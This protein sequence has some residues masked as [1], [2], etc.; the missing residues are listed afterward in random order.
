MA[1][2]NGHLLTVQARGHVLYLNRVC[3]TKSAAI[4][5][6]VSKTS[7]FV[8]HAACTNHEKMRSEPSR[9][10]DLTRVA[11]NIQKK[12]VLYSFCEPT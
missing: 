12:C 6:T 2:A 10:E 1:L 3:D 8:T 4:G 7:A 5:E 11:F 9:R